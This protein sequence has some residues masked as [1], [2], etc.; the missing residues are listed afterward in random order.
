MH[1]FIVA[2]AGL[3]GTVTGADEVCT[4]TILGPDLLVAKKGKCRGP[5]AGGDCTQ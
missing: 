3:S 5:L 4:Q 1:R 2:P